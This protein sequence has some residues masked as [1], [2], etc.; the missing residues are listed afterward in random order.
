[1][2]QFMLFSGLSI[3]SQ[4]AGTAIFLAGRVLYH[5]FTGKIDRRG[6]LNQMMEVGPASLII[7]LLTAASIGM[8]F[9][10]QVTR[11]FLRFGA[12]SA[13]GGI[14][15]IALARELSPVLTAVV[16][17]GRVGAAF[18]AELGTANVTEQIDALYVLKT[19]PVEYL[20]VPRV[21]ACVIMT[22]ALTILSLFT[23]MAGGLWI[24]HSQ[25][26]MNPDV[27][28][29]SVQNFVTL[30]D[31]CSSPIKAAVFGF[32]IAIIGCNW[33][34]TTQG[35]ARGVGRSTTAAVVTSLLA[36]FFSDFFLSW[37]M[38][39]GLGTAAFNAL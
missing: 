11:E 34:L 17:A 28:M 19:D 7:V 20:V 27:F 2:Q 37:A 38:F 32:L 5:I 16:I 39:Q 6:T 33:G 13:V 4:R 24:A 3:W 36:I 26:N 23:G 22:P 35:G 12:G 8:V 25:Y 14:L 1:M 30:W 18:A 10:I 9:T 31:L 15:G 29:D 21:I